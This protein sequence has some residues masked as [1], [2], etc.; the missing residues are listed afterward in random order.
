MDTKGT[1]RNKFINHV[2]CSAANNKFLTVIT[3]GYTSPNTQL[4]LSAI[5]ELPKMSLKHG[6]IKW[7]NICLPGKW[8]R[9]RN[10]QCLD[11]GSTTDIRDFVNLTT[12]YS[13]EET[14]FLKIG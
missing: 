8:Q 6:S 3:S 13:R 14:K 1:Q 7:P 5:H 4:P 2:N 9:L 10:D 11:C 12:K